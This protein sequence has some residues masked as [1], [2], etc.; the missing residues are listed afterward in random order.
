M[1]FRFSQSDLVPCEAKSVLKIRNKSQTMFLSQTWSD[2]CLK[3]RKNQD[4]IFPIFIYFSITELLLDSVGNLEILSKS[5]K[6]SNLAHVVRVV[7]ER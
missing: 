3:G 7:A 2:T 4:Q 6:Q 1:Y 5:W